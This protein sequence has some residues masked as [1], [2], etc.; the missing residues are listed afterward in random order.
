MAVQQTKR[1][2]WK[3]PIDVKPVEEA[4][5]PTYPE[6]YAYMPLDGPTPKITNRGRLVR[7]RKQQ[8]DLIWVLTHSCK[9]CYFP[10]DP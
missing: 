7:D 8:Y 9:P 2:G 10:T 4:P 1:G 3:G 6:V 5:N